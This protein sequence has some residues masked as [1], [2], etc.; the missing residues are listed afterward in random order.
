[1]NQFESL[2]HSEDHK[3]RKEDCDFR[4]FPRGSG[5]PEFLALE[6]QVAQLVLAPEQQVAP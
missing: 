2:I 5:Q 3:A 4:E 1:M 6:Q